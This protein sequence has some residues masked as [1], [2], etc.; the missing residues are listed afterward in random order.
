MNEKKCRPGWIPYVWTAFIA[1]FLCF[2]LAACGGATGGGEETDSGSG[3][4][5]IVN[6]DGDSLGC[7]SCIIIRRI[8]DPAEDERLKLE[9]AQ[10]ENAH[11]PVLLA[12]QDDSQNPLTI[13]TGDTHQYGFPEPAELQTRIRFE[14][15]ADK[16]GVVLSEKLIINFVFLDDI[17]EG[18]LPPYPTV[19]NLS[20]DTGI[21]TTSP[22]CLSP[23]ASCLGEYDDSVKPGYFDIPSPPFAGP[24]WNSRILV[25]QVCSATIT[26]PDEGLVQPVSSNPLYFLIKPGFP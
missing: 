3:I 2:V 23:W 11:N 16:A 17:P 8:C 15:G 20:S 9:I 12:D 10:V 4:G 19:T 26:D 21:L 13:N 5:P 24:D 25:A 22:T 18:S 7:D 1:L 14:I 6:S